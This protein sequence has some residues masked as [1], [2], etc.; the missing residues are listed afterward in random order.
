LLRDGGSPASAFPFQILLGGDL[1]LLPV[2]PVVLVKVPIFCSNDRVLKIAGDLVKR[3][4]CGAWPVRF[5]LKPG[6]PATLHLYRRCRWINPPGRQEHQRGQRPKKHQDDDD[7]TNKGPQEA[8]S[9]SGLR[10]CWPHVVRL[11]GG[12]RSRGKEPCCDRIPYSRFFLDLYSTV[13]ARY[14]SSPRRSS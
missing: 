3:K 5:V 14:I 12:S 7:P 1:D 8:R 10:L 4:K 11:Q 13:N 6:L 2:E 9:K